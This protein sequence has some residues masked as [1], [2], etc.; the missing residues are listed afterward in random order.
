MPVSF[1]ALWA[2]HPTIKGDAPLL[3]RDVY[4]DQCAI[5]LAAAF[6]RA[7][8]SFDRFPGTFSWQADKPKYP[9]RAQEFANWF[10]QSQGGLMHR[11]E[12]YEGKDGFEKIAGRSGVI[13]IQNY[14]GPGR[15]GDHIDLWS[16][17]RLTDFSSWFRVHMGISWEGLMTDYRKASAIWFWYVP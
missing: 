14:W 6:M 16:G 8:V 7:G 15:Q 13:F 11:V 5:N 3:D 4:K 9:I 10:S 2:N 1:A 17:A 12:K